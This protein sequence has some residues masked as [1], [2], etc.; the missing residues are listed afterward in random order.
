MTK[1]LR[2]K[3]M[4]RSKLNVLAKIETTKIDTSVN[5]KKLLNLMKIKSKNF[6]SVNVKSVADN[7][8]LW[9]VIQ[10]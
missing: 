9:K 4:K 2:K 5:S 8:T 3:I 7:K 6:E 10:Q 1:D